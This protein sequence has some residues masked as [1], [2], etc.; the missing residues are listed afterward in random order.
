MPPLG[1]RQVGDPTRDTLHRAARPV[2]YLPPQR[3]L[4][5]APPGEKGA[6]AHALA[7]HEDL[8]GAELL[9]GLCRGGRFFGPNPALYLEAGARRS[10]DI[11]CGDEPDRFLP[12]EGQCQLLVHLAFTGERPAIVVVE[13]EREQRPGSLEAV[14]L[15]R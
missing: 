14:L 12:A 10:G 4:L 8:D 5:V 6:A 11:S 2:P 15:A 13:G 1:G 9:A 7:V 3:S